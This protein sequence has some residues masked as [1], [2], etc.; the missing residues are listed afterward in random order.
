MK[1]VLFDA[2][3]DLPSAV[4]AEMV[5]SQDDSILVV[6]PIAGKIKTYAPTARGFNKD[7]FRINM[8]VLLP[9]DCIQGDDAISDF[10]AFVVMRLPKSRVQ[11]DFIHDNPELLQP[12]GENKLG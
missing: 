5:G 1:T 6:A 11:D 10:G 8:D 12:Q 9:K 3:K 7:Y 4:A 2:P